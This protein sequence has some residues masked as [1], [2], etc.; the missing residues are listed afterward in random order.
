MLLAAHCQSVSV[1]A[2][3]S[4][5]NP[6]ASFLLA[7]E[8]VAFISHPGDVFARSFAAGWWVAESGRPLLFVGPWRAGT[9]LSV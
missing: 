7:V 6:C 3:F 9:R 4:L 5:M 8:N 1:P 2:E